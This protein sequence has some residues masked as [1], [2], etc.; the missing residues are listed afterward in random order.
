MI[1]ID[2]SLVMRIYVIQNAHLA[3]TKDLEKTEGR[4]VPPLRD[5]WNYCIGGCNCSFGYQVNWN[6]VTVFFCKPGL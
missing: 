5:D 2:N 4:G 6:A 3:E 1:L